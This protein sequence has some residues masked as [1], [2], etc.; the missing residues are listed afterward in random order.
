MCAAS[1]DRSSCS[2]PRP[3]SRPSLALAA[4]HL[5]SAVN[6][7]GWGGPP[8]LVVLTDGPEESADAEPLPPIGP[9][10]DDPVA[11]LLG[12]SVPDDGSGLAVVTEGT[13]RRLLDGAEM[14]KSS[15]VEPYRLAYVVDRQGRVGSA[16]RIEGGTPV[17]NEF[18]PGD[19]NR[20]SGRLVDVCHRALGLTTAPPPSDT[21]SLWRLMWLDQILARAVDGDRALEWTDVAP[22][23]PALTLVQEAEGPL[24]PGFEI[25][26]QALG[27]IG[28]VLGRVKTWKEL[29][30]ANSGG[31][32][33]AHGLTAEHAAWMD[34]GMYARWVIGEYL[35]ENVYR[36]ELGDVLPTDVLDK[37]A[38]VV[39]AADQ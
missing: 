34:A 25:D 1:S 27:R 23:H 36:S 39:E 19:E 17:V 13:G 37:I 9:G 8:L 35:P 11:D 15:S 24:P 29:R 4:R 3:H 28:V 26:A 30:Q 10:R 18:E 21:T 22:L 33:S 2:R 5:E 12:Y 7:C 38:V 14:S 6:E 16:T 20:P 32:W 31:S